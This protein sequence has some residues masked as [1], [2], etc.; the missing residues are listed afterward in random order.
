MTCTGNR[1]DVTK[2]FQGAR[3]KQWGEGGQEA[4]EAQRSRH[5]RDAV[6]H[7]NIQNTKQNIQVHGGTTE[8]GPVTVREVN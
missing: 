5:E 3:V 4:K 6:V 7:R 1:R 8:E 2:Y